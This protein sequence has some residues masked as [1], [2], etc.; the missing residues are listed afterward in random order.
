[1]KPTAFASLGPAPTG[2]AS[3]PI[4]PLQEGM[5]QPQYLSQPVLNGLYEPTI[6]NIN[7]GG[8]GVTFLDNNASIEIEFNPSITPIVEYV[9]IAN[10]SITNVNQVSVTII[11]S[12]GSIIE[13]LNSLVGN[14]FVSGFPLTP[15]PA[16]STLYITFQTSDQAPPQNVT[17]SIIA[18]FNAE[19]ITTGVSTTPGYSTTGG[20]FKT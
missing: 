5:G 6:P 19:L 10:P 1:M 12:N 9:S 13:T 4:C 15:L 18:C 20:R 7:P 8:E 14:N 2:T 11:A 3:T 17:I 16:S